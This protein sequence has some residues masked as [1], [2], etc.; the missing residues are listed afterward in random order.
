MIEESQDLQTHLNLATDFTGNLPRMFSTM[1]YG[2]WLFLGR[3][4]S[5]SLIWDIFFSTRERESGLK[6]QSKEYLKLKYQ[7][8]ME[9][10]FILEFR[11]TF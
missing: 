7:S 9:T 4:I 1:S 8:K 2:R 6:T 11:S 10:S 5:G 3:R